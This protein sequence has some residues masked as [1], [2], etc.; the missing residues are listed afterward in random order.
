MNSK[1]PILNEAD[2]SEAR[3][4]TLDVLRNLPEP[5][6]LAGLAREAD[7]PYHSLYM[8]RSGGS[9]SMKYIARLQKVLRKYG[10]L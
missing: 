8:F 3:I 6:K 4:K 1:I 2:L 9:M 5:I 7:I 10:L